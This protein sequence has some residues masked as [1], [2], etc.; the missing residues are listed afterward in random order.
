M[1]RA[2]PSGLQISCDNAYGVGCI[3]NS[4]LTVSLLSDQNVRS[5]S[6]NQLFFL[7]GVAPNTAPRA[8]KDIK[9]CLSFENDQTLLQKDKYVVKE[10]Y[11]ASTEAFVNRL[12][13]TDEEGY[14]T[15]QYH[16]KYDMPQKKIIPLEEENC[17]PQR[18]CL[19]FVLIKIIILSMII[20]IRMI[21]IIII[22]Q[23]N[24]YQVILNIQFYY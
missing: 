13:D 10:V 21:I 3:L 2:S 16:H 11:T 14:I 4:L 1:F 20:L 5:Q 24:Y 6:Y 22:E 17:P 19:T 9:M 18:Q 8:L 12:V 23:I 15:M 7:V